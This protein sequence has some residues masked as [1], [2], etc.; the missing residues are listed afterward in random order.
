[1]IR[2][3]ACDMDGTLMDENHELP[4][5]SYQIIH[6]LWTEGV[7]FCVSSGRPYPFLAETFAPVKDEMDF[8]CSNGAHVVVEGKTIDRELFSYGGIMKLKRFCD[9]FDCMHLTVTGSHGDEYL[10]DDDPAKAERFYD[11]VKEW[12]D[13]HPPAITPPP[14]LN[15]LT[16]SVLIA[17]DHSAMD[18]AYILNMEMGD[19]FFFAPTDGQ[20]IDF[21]PAHVN[22]ATGIK[23]VMEHYDV[24]REETMAYGDSMNDYDIFRLV[25][26]P[27][28]MQNALYALRQVAERII[29]P[30]Y[31]RGVQKDMLR[32]LADLRAGGDGLSLPDFREVYG[33]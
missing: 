11:F 17:D 27:V 33:F 9:G 26:H 7:R 23:Q 21:M 10:L 2:L 30:N 20:S 12:G 5:E 3:I 24:W 19:I 4:P 32:L 1:M 29:E 8:V 18:M 13:F 28:A 6:D 14:T 16:A 15:I 25:G 22:K 31:E